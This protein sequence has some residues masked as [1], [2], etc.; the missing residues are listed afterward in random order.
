MSPNKCMRRSQS[1][2]THSSVLFLSRRRMGFFIRLLGFLA[3]MRMTLWTF[4]PIHHLHHLLRQQM[5]STCPITPNV[6]KEK[7]FDGLTFVRNECQ[8]FLDYSQLP[9]RSTRNFGLPFCLNRD[10]CREQL[11]K[12]LVSAL[13]VHL[14][15][16]I[17]LYIIYS[18]ETCWIWIM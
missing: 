13:S 7:P 3:E 18:Y 12:D 14:S 17:N 8:S 16:S 4:F 9:P 1:T 5:L 15:T 2:S 10:P 6:V 11:A